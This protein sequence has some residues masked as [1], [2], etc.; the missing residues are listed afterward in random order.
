[1][2]KKVD[3]T[4]KQEGRERGDTKEKGQFIKDRME[5]GAPR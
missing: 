1:M 2:T 3:S 4:K 5:N